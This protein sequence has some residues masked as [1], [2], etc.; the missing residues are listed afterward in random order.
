MRCLVDLD[1]TRVVRSTKLL[2]PYCGL[3]A[4]M[5]VRAPVRSLS[6]FR[7]GTT[8]VPKLTLFWS[9]T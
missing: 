2:F 8:F 6:S 7:I 4:M 3:K 9:S 5:S 1:Q